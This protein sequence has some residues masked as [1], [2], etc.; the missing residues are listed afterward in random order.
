MVT[1]ITGKRHKDPQDPKWVKWEM[2]FYKTGYTR[3]LRVVNTSGAYK[4]WDQESQGFKFIGS[5]Y[6]KKNQLLLDIKEKCLKLL[7]N[8][9]E[10]NTISRPYSGPIVSRNRKK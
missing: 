9:S 5:E 1:T 8:G 7:N 4:S 2:V 10:K 6:V 3:I